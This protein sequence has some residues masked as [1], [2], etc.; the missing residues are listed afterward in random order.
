MG[1]IV[2]FV[3]RWLIYYHASLV[4]KDAVSSCGH[5]RQR[6]TVSE[7]KRSSI[8]SPAI[9]IDNRLVIT[10]GF[11]IILP[12]CWSMALTICSTLPY[13]FGQTGLS[14]QCRPR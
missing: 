3:V 11:V 14:K 6:R 7:L 5:R 12:V 2:G 8:I 13:A 4:A 10:E 9:V 1:L